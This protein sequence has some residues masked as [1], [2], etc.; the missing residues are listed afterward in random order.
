MR[1]GADT[2]A[3]AAPLAGALSI[4]EEDGEA[5]AASEQQPEDTLR[6]AEV[7]WRAA[8]AAGSSGA[9]H[10]PAA[11]A[12]LSCRL[13]WRAEPGAPSHLWLQELR[14]EEEPPAACRWLG[15][16]CHGWWQAQGVPVGPGC[17]GVRWLVLPGS[18]GAAGGRG[19]VLAC[20]VAA[21]I[22]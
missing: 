4:E 20:E 2:T 14:G 10:G 9:Q 15:M 8:A 18:R 5:A 12:Q 17:Q 11:A 6:A 1:A 13:E 3:V 16:T 22:V 7:Q 21:A 19:G